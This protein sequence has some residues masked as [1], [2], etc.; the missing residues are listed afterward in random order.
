VHLMFLCIPLPELSLRRIAV[1]LSQGGHHIPSDVVRRRFSR[2][3][4]NLLHIY[5]A[6]CDDIVILDNQGDAPHK[7]AVLTRTEEIVHDPA[8]YATLVEQ[9]KGET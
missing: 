8:A 6:W 2:S 1:R 7:V 3:M 5:R 4:R 9:A